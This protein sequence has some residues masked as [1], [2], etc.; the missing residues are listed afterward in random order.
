MTTFISSLSLS[1]LCR[2]CTDRL[3]DGEGGGEGEVADVV[4]RSLHL[5]RAHLTQIMLTL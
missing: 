2:L 5:S 4:H 3:R 1:F